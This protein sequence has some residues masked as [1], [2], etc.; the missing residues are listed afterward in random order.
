M[1]NKNLP[2]KIV[3]ASGNAHKIE[4]IKA[5]F[6]GVELVTM[7]EA[8]FDGDIE[9]NGKTFKEN[10]YIK[11][12]AV[13]DK[14]RLP[15]LA[16]DSG[17]CVDALDGAPGV[18]SARFSGGT[19]ADNRA[20]LLKRLEGVYQRSAHFTCSVCYIAADGKPVFGEGQ[21]NGRILLEETGEKGFGYDSLF[22]S[23]DLQKSF[24]EA[25]ESEKNSVSHRYRA[26]CNLREKL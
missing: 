15:V 25:S 2:E 6:K 20:L 26:L 7:H 24:G 1:S 13:F 14:L 18:Y 3:V 9:E 12:Q 17:L 8:G 11:A 22:Y 23:D 19:S 5:I 10:A 21:T 16:D 4:E